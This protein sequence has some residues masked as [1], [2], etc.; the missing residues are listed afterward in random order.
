M[1]ADSFYGSVN[2]GD[3][4]SAS[5]VFLQNGWMVG[6]AGSARVANL[7]EHIF[8][9]P[10]APRKPDEKAMVHLA[11]SVA[12]LIAGDDLCLE[13]EDGH[14]SVASSILVAV[15]NQLYTINADLS[16]DRSRHGYQTVGC[17]S[18]YASGALAA[19]SKDMPP[20]DRA[21]AA[22][23]AAARHSPGVR[24]PFHVFGQ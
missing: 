23:R 13:S 19:L 24:G 3:S 18:Y 9:W 20:R 16:V 11:R 10:R 21:L 2:C 7:L 15:G 6:C 22:L 14:K 1:G 4:L 17:G 5:K 12:K 8:K